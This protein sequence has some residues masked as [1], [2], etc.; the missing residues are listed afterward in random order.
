MIKSFQIGEPSRKSGSD[1]CQR[2]TLQPMTS[3]KRHSTHH[4]IAK[5]RPSP[6]PC[7]INVESANIRI[8]SDRGA[9][10]DGRFTITMSVTII[11]IVDL[12]IHV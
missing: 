10:V 4:N 11:V 6:R 12:A 7:L 2:N 5:Q 8:T 1:R 9:L 3:N